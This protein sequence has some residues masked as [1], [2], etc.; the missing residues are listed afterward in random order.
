MPTDASARRVLSFTMG[1][2]A[3][4]DL[5]GAVIY[6]AIRPRIPECSPP[7]ADADPFRSAMRTIMSAHRDAVVRTSKESRASLA[8]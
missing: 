8:A 2:A 5:T 3:I 7:M 6:R 4:F 1:I